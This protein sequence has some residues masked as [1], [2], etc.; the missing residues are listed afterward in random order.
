[1]GKMAGRE[2]YIRT[3]RTLPTEQQKFVSRAL[4]AAGE[5][6]EDAAKGSI[7]QGSA[8]GKRHVPSRPGEPPMNDTGVLHNNIETVMKGPLTVEIS[9]NA[10]YSRALEYG[11]SR[12]AER[13]FMRPALAKSRTAVGKLIDDAVA[14]AV[15][16]AKS[17]G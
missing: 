5:M 10:P 16:K 17:G 4:F 1:M 3:I 7:M 13:P 15:R 11:T 2:R 14:H 12:M 8:S 9:S 6:V